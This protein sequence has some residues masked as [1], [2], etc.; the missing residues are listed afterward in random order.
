MLTRARFALLLAGLAA[1]PL[2]RADG[3]AVVVRVGSRSMSAGEVERRVRAMAPFQLAELGKS[4][5]EVKR[6]FV[7]RVVAPELLYA[8]EAESRKLSELPHVADRIREV[9][10][11][12]LENEVRESLA[13]DGGVTALDVKRYYDENL[14]RFNTPRRIKIWRI[15][16]ADEESAKKVIQEV[17]KVAAEPTVVWTSLARERSVDKAT[18]MRDGNLGFVH[19]DGKTETPEVRVDPALFVAADQVKD[20]EL[21]QTPVKEGEKWAVVWRRGS[22]PAVERTLAQ[23]ERT[24][25]QILMRKKLQDAT[26]ELL[27]SLEKSHVKGKS[28][29][30]LALVEIDPMGDI[31]ERARPGVVPRHKPRATGSPRA[32]ERGLR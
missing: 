4:A 16:T 10:R 9:L 13:K 28:A 23:E 15:L 22:M 20:G 1:A 5:G 3:D 24:I 19:P 32:S 17:R 26:A 18:H 29:D 12:A 7:D 21:V 27:A 25:R 6:A 30:L 11:Q 8:E 31:V 2:A 14:H